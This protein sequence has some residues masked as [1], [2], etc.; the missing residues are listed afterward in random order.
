MFEYHFIILQYIYMFLI[1]S[2]PK[3]GNYLLKDLLDQRGIHLLINQR[4]LKNLQLKYENLLYT[5]ILYIVRIKVYMYLTGMNTFKR[6]CYCMMHT[7]SLVFL[8]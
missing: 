4:M 3:N 2:H 6:S 1:V 5:I 7:F 8:L